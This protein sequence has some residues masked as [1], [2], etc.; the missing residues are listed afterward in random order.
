MD[1]M[2]QKSVP[3]LLPIAMHIYF[4]N[5]LLREEVSR[6]PVKNPLKFN[7]ADFRRLS[8]IFIGF[9]AECGENKR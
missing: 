3:S 9:L 5:N 8:S 7:V 4:G 1:F 2:D 6:L